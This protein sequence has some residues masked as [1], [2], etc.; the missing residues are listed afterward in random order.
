LATD[1]HEGIIG[2]FRVLPMWRPAVLVGR[3]LADL[4]T[5]CLFPVRGN[6]ATP[7]AG[8]GSGRDLW[9]SCVTRRSAS[10]IP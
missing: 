4:L 3:S 10:S 5:D 6:P 1:L 8:D 2:R 9:G 7:G